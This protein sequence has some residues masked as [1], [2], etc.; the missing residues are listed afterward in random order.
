MRLED[1]SLVLRVDCC[2]YIRVCSSGV[3]VRGCFA[4]LIVMSMIL[5][6]PSVTHGIWQ[7]LGAIREPAILGRM[8]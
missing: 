8:L 1:E 7:H 3:G 2:V 5:R 6:L 4:L